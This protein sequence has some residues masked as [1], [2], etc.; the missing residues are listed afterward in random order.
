MREKIIKIAAIILMAVM[1]YTG[2]GLV[3]PAIGQ[4]HAPDI[5]EELEY[6]GEQT[7]VRNDTDLPDFIGRIIKFAVG[8]IGVILVAI[9]IYAGFMYA[10]SAGNEKQLETAKKTMVYAIIGVIIIAIAWALT[11]FVLS[12]L[13]PT[14]RV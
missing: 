7:P 2:L 11:D 3:M 10:T 14:K 9:F 8:L 6:V 4:D 5:I 1:F 12:A 13:F